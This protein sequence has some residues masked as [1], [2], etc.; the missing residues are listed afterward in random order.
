MQQNELLVKRYLRPNDLYV[1][2]EIQ[3]A[4]S[5]IIKNHNG[6]EIPPKTLLEAGTMAVCYR[7]DI[8]STIFQFIIILF[9]CC[10]GC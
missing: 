3:G 9:S 5:I 10:L 4:S 7:Y 8:F 6:G 1:H 2:A